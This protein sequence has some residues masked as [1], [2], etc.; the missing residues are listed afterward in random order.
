LFNC[1][2]SKPGAGH[3]PSAYLNNLSAGWPRQVHHYQTRQRISARIRR[4][5][6]WSKIIGTRSSLV[7]GAALAEL[8]EGEFT[9]GHERD[10]FRVSTERKSI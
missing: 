3:I 6:H 5:A 9:E 10:G 7:M 4:I 8:D 2:S 1:V